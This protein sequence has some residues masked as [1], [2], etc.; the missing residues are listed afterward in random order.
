M[1]G[2]IQEGQQSREDPY[3]VEGVAL[4]G[5]L[6]VGEGG[7]VAQD[8][9]ARG[10]GEDERLEIGEVVVAGAANVCGREEREDIFRRLGQ[11][12]ELAPSSVQQQHR[13]Q[14]RA[15]ASPIGVVGGDLLGL[16]QAE[17]ALLEGQFRVGCTHWQACHGVMCAF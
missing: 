1:V 4:R 2:F 16:R 5:Q 7:V 14:G 15:Y 3:A 10:D 6:G 9:E 13:G 8:Y 17:D 11:L 12:P